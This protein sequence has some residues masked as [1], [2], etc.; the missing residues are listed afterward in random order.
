MDGFQQK[1]LDLLTAPTMQRAFR[2]DQEPPPVSDAYGRNL[3][4]QSV[5]LARRLVEAGARLVC[6]SWAPDANATWDT[7][8]GNFQK[9]KT[10]L[11]PQLDAALAALL[12]D[13]HARGMLGC[14]L[15][16]VMGEFG[17]I[18]KVNKNQGGRDQA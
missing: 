17:R 14:T 9:L 16:A 18:P 3:Y 7:H 4:G 11:L 15:V 5:L 8:G 1:A 6:V 13:L 2:M 10:Q 12:D